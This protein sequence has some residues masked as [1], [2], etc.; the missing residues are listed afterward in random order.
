MKIRVCAASSFKNTVSRKWCRPVMPLTG[1][2]N[3]RCPFAHTCWLR[4]DYFEQWKVK[5]N[6]QRKTM[7][8][9]EKQRKTKEKQRKIRKISIWFW[10]FTKVKK[11]KN[12]SQSI[13]MEGFREGRTP[14]G[15]SIERVGW[16]V[17]SSKWTLALGK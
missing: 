5:K 12:T 16:N 7:K 13:W 1:D 6:Q 8:N 15:A 17:L 4:N 9:K 11:A 14:L 10:F 3:I 2:Q